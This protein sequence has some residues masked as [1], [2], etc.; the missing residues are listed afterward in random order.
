M[1]DKVR[2][3][4]WEHGA[5]LFTTWMPTNWW[6]SVFD[7]LLYWVFVWPGLIGSFHGD[8][9]DSMLDFDR[10]RPDYFDFT[11][12]AIPVSRWRVVIPAYLAFCREHLARTGF[13]PALPTEIYLIR[14]DAQSRLSFSAAEDIF[15]LDMV[16][17]RPRP[18]GDDARWRAM[19][20]EFNRFVASHGGR[21]LLNQTKE[22]TGPV[23]ARALGDDWRAFAALV[24]KEDPAGRFLS[25][26]FRE[27]LAG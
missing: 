14:Q 12:W 19:N 3:L 27:L 4:A 7:R 26:Y 21:P 6:F 20:R 8:R 11:F 22:L 23:V 24:Q 18:P 13:R 25:D 15:T 9:V 16:D 10:R 1:K 2:D 5:S 17:C